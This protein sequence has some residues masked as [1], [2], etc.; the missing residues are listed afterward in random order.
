MTRSVGSVNY[1]L[2]VPLVCSV[3]SCSMPSD[4]LPRHARG[5]LYWIPNL[6][7]QFILSLRRRS[8]LI[9]TLRLHIQLLPWLLESWRSSA[10]SFR[11]T[12]A[13]KGSGE[14]ERGPREGS[15]YRRRVMFLSHFLRP[16]DPIQSHGSWYCTGLANGLGYGPLQ[17]DSNTHFGHLNSF[18]QITV[19]PVFDKER[20]HA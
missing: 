20:G 2:R 8:V 4:L 9:V 11:L 10:H 16:F 19:L 6:T 17:R 7:V 3:M 12:W 14:R 13:T 15:I 18:K 1:L 5:T